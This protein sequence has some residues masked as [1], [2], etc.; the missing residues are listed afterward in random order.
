MADMDKD[1]IMKAWMQAAT[2]GEN[3]KALAR[4]VGDW[5]IGTKSWMDGPQSAPTVSKGTVETRWLMDGRWLIDKVTAE[6]MGQPFNGA[7]LT[8]Y[9]N[10]KKKYVGIWLDS[11]ST[12]MMTMEGN[13][14][15]PAT[16]VMFGRYDDPASGEHDRLQRFVTRIEGEDRHVMTIHELSGSVEGMLMMEIAYTRVKR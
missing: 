9:D 16:L 13:F 1:A 14:V 4:F 10:V 15:D 8:G 2:L 5:E 6:M 3:H 7:S 12:T 11:M